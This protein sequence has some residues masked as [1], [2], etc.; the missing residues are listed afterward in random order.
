MSDLSLWLDTSTQDTSLALIE[1]SEVVSLKVQES[2]ALDYLFET[3]QVLLDETQN[4]FSDLQSI[5]YCSGPGSSLG[6]R[7]LSMALRT[8]K[9]T[10]PNIQLMAGY[11]LPVYAA[12]EALRPNAPESFT[13]LA[14]HRKDTWYSTVHQSGTN[15][16]MNQM[17]DSE[18]QSLDGTIFHIRQ[19][20]FATQPPESS[21]LLYPNLKALPNIIGSARLFEATD[22][23]TVFPETTPAFKKWTPQRHRSPALK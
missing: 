13:L 11:T 7:I 16:E 19:R 14:Q 23:P 1:N 2:N 21:Q 18:V 4:R 3:L 5:Y 15:L 6:L 22:V 10:H 12:L 20:K 8:W 17:S 9:V